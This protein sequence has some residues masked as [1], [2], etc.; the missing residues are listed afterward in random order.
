M[1]RTNL[2]LQFNIRK[3]KSKMVPYKRGGAE[4]AR[5]LT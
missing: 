4:V 5:N 1:D 2:I 3:G